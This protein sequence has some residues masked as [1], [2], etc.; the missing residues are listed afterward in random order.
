[1]SST[2]LDFEISLLVE[3][4]PSLLPRWLCEAIHFGLKQSGLHLGLPRFKVIISN[5]HVV[6]SAR[7]AVSGTRAFCGKP[8]EQEHPSKSKF[9][10]VLARVVECI[11]YASIAG[12]SNL[13]IVSNCLTVAARSISATSAFSIASTA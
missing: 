2:T 12:V 6:L 11:V 8:L 3:L 5:E 9:K 10:R 4:R 7:S 1:M 13:A